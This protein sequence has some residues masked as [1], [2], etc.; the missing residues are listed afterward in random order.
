MLSQNNLVSYQYRYVVTQKQLNPFYKGQ[1][2][3]TKRK[4]F[5]AMLKN[6]KN[7]KKPPKLKMK[8]ETKF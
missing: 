2:N 3:I 5:I 4:T 6:T 7:Q 8:L 1:G